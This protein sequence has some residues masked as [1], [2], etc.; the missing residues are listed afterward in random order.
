M[1]TPEQPQPNP[2]STNLEALSKLQS[3]EPGSVEEEAQ[4]SLINQITDTLLDHL[5]LLP[6]E[7]GEFQWELVFKYFSNIYTFS[8]TNCFLL[9]KL[10]YIP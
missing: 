10:I 6:S 2:E 9:S 7:P 1:P 4:K 3:F 8:L 5:S